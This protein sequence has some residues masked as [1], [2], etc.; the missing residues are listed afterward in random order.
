MTDYIPIY[1]D[2]VD[3]VPDMCRACD[4]NYRFGLRKAINIPSAR[5]IWLYDIDI[6]LEVNGRILA[7]GEYKRYKKEY[8][9]FLIPAFEYV[10]LKKI[11]KLMRVPCFLIIE[12]VKPKPC[13]SEYRVWMVDRFE[14]PGARPM[15]E[16]MGKK[17]AVFNPEYAL[18]LDTNGLKV[19]LNALVMS[20]VGD[21]VDGDE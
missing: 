13:E 12:L 3:R 8:K 18:R 6:V 15:K 4:N 10:A 11:A 19:W 5:S 21:S 9:E 2:D 7:I 20:L 16:M 1:V 17:C 14:P